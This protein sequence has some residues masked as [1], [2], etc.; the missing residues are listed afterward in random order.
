MS[1]EFPHDY[2]SKRN[3][4]FRCDHYTNGMPRD[5]TLPVAI[6]E[7]DALTLTVRHHG[8]RH[9]VRIPVAKLIEH[10]PA[11]TWKQDNKDIDKV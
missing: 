5:C 11:I 3:F 7:D 1:A 8:E 9:F 10:I 2:S 4:V 6:Y